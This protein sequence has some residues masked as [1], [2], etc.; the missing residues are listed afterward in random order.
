[1]KT[2][3]AIAIALAVAAASAFSALPASAQSAE[4]L[5]LSLKARPPMAPPVV[6]PK[7]TMAAPVLPTPGF[8]GY[9]MGKLRSMATR[10]LAASER[11]RIA[12][13]VT[14]AARPSIDLEIYFAYDSAA[15]DPS[16]L[17]GL[18]ALGQALS[19]PRLAGGVFLIAGHTDASGSDWYNQSL[20][21]RRAWSVR[22]FLIATFRLD[23]HSLVAV[24][25]GE[26]LLRDRYHPTSGVNRRVQIANLAQ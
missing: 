8:A 6:V 5:I 12:A 20:S 18:Y 11:G 19:D 22:N 2:G 23:P 3:F 26:E 16:A 15:I 17:P 13:M 14:A 4:A 21:E 1:M 7:A 10:R 9:D 24:G 25:Y